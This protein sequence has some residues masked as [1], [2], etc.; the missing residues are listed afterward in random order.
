MTTRQLAAR[1]NAALAR[2]V[3]DIDRVDG[4]PRYGWLVDSASTRGVYYSVTPDYRCNCPAGQAGTP[5]RHAA[6]AYRVKHNLGRSRVTV[7][8]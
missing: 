5:C 6:A 8:G 2:S 3:D 4:D 1:R 7:R